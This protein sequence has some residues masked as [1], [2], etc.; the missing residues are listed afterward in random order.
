[1]IDP[2]AV[3]GSRGGIVIRI[4]GNAA[5]PRGS[6]STNIAIFD[7]ICEL[8]YHLTKSG[9]RAVIV[10][11]GFGGHIFLDWARNVG[12]SDALMNE[13]GSS[14][15]DISAY[16]LADSFSRLL[17]PREVKCDPVVPKSHS[18]LVALYRCNDVVF[19]GSSIK[20]AISSDSLSLL[21]G[22]ALK[23]PV[24][25]IKRANPFRDLPSYTEREFTSH[26][27]EVNLADIS[28]S[29][30]NGTEQ[31]GA[32]FHPALDSWSL[33]LLRRDDASLFVTDILS[34]LGFSE[35]GRLE[36]IIKVVNE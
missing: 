12:C 10:P 24:L 3:A 13:V 18:E 21:I 6:N 4:G 8:V 17:T 31:D 34:I 28:T 36:N 23:L 16:I 25:S 20:G 7:A 32:G 30:Y 9:N 26:T 1:M 2:V 19:S 29:I 27:A 14:L 35:V 15:I 11:G 33:R 5:T 22:S